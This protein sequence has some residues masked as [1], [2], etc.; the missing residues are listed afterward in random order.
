MEYVRANSED[1]VKLHDGYVLRNLRKDDF[2][3]GYKDLLAG[4]TQVGSFTESEF[5]RA[6]D[7]RTNCVTQVVE[8]EPT[9][10]IA[11]T[12]TLVVE[13]K[14][15]HNCQGVGHIE[16]VSTSPDHRRQGLVK[17]ILKSLEC[18][19][20][21]EECYK[22]ILDCKQHNVAV[23]EKCGFRVTDEV[24]MRLDVPPRNK[25]AEPKL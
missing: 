19:A 2:R 5:V 23:Y 21:D 1:R 22:M 17:L 10:I 9:H 8:H 24:E 3:K 11:A 16:D 4:L 6:F 18:V 20:Q 14:F 15:V 7:K 25:S 12:V 13:Q